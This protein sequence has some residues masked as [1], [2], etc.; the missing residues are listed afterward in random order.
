MPQDIIFSCLNP[1]MGAKGHAPV[2][3]EVAQHR[4]TWSIPWF[5]GDGWL[6]HLQF[7]AASVSDQ[8]KAAYADKLS[9]VVG[10]HWRT[11][12]IRPNLEAFAVTAGDPEQAPPAEELY[13][14]HCAARY[15]TASV[16]TLA[17]LLLQ[18]EKE[19]QL[20]YLNSPEFYPYDPKWGRL[21]AGLAEKLRA[22]IESVS[23]LKERT[24]DAASTARILIGWPTI[25]DSRC[26]WTR[27]DGSWSRPTLSRRSPSR[28]TEGTIPCRA[29]K[30]KRPGGNW[31]PLRSKNSS[32]PLRD[33]F[34]HA[35]N[36][37]N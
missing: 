16:E 22:A 28:W 23:R 31:P 3:A 2:L 17:P 35:A 24:P 6:W 18:F 26:C 5:E 13:R 32:S 7:R 15:G 12:E 30:C 25:C 34:A 11:E 9:G 20:G 37:A 1:G 36:L 29:T 33:V 19:N 21:P 27:S 4:P 10:I 14:R 8:V